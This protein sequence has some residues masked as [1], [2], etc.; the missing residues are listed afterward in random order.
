M[1]MRRIRTSCL[2]GWLLT[3]GLSCLLSPTTLAFHVTPAG[4]VG[5]SKT[6]VAVGSKFYMSVPVLD[7]WVTLP[8]GSIYGTVYNSL[9]PTIRD[10]DVIST[11]PLKHPEL[12]QESALVETW[13]GTEYLLLKSALATQ[14]GSSALASSTI[15]ETR[16]SITNSGDGDDDTTEVQMLLQQVRDAGISG[17]I[18]Y[19]L[20]ELGF[21]AV[22]VPLCIVAYQQV[23][24]HWPDISNSEDLAK[25]GM[26][27]LVFVNVARFAVPV[28]IGLALS[29]VPWVQ[30]NIVDPFSNSVQKEVL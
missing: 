20:W 13:T 14:G 8:N 29:T 10:G 5:K 9:D 21:W 15:Q 3:C 4:S 27:A 16:S 26:E 2:L 25:L 7:K 19:A 28:R 11:S 18:S 1:L 17:A 24:G 6:G 23:F 30:K 22:S 12:A